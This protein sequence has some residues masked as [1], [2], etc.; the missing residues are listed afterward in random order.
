MTTQHPFSFQK[1]E[2]PVKDTW[3]LHTFHHK[4]ATF[5]VGGIGY[6]GQVLRSDDEGLTWR[7]SDWRKSPK[8]QGWMNDRHQLTGLRQIFATSLSELYA[9]GESGMIL[10]STD[11]GE[12][13]SYFDFD[14][15]GCLFGVIGFQKKIFVSGGDGICA[16][17]A[18]GWP[19]LYKASSKLF[20]RLYV[21][22]D[23]LWC[24]GDN[25]L[26]VRSDDGKSF[27]RI[28]SSTKTNLYSFVGLPDG[29]RVLAGGE[30]G[31]LLLSKKDGK[32]FKESRRE[33]NVCW[34]G[35]I[36]VGDSVLA[37]GEKGKMVVSHDSAE[38]WQPIQSPITEDL[39]S[40]AMTDKGTI[41]VVGKK[42]TILRAAQ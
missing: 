20:G 36:V 30:G 3:F 33:E 8:L 5:I 38:T 31:S 19:V 2:S 34:N 7:A 6:D 12:S 9:V 27:A 37:I 42:G 15:N 1:I 40:G 18:G 14:H 41:I 16:K 28:A 25:G 23:S 24:V 32:R 11:G 35:L 26:L 13:F 39:W 17:M 4:G 10:H 29:E 22:G 21:W